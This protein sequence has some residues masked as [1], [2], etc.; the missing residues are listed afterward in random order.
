MERAESELA[1][2][3]ILFTDVVGSTELR[4]RLGDDRADA[5]RRAHDEMIGRAI[6]ANHGVLLRWTGD[7]VKAAFPTSSTAIAAAIA[8]QRAV[9]SYGRR[10]DAV[11][12]FQIRVGV[13]VGEVTN[14]DGDD[15]GVAVIEAARLEALAAPGEILAT[16]LVERLGYRRT[17]AAFED[18]GSRT[19]KGLEKP[20]SIV[21]VL[22]IA[23]DATVLPMPR[24]L[25]LDRRFPLVG[26]SAAME[27]LVR[28]WNAAC[29]GSAGTLLITGQPGMGKTR[30]IAQAA[31]HAHGDGAIVLAGI[32]DSELAVP[33]QPFAMALRETRLTDE[34]LAIA[35]STRA[36]ALGPLFPGSRVSR[37][38]DQGPAARFELFEAVAALLGRLSDLQPMVLVLEDLQWA[39]PPTLLLL[40]HL[41]QH[42]D[43]AR[44][45]I[46]GTYRDEEVA[47]NPQLRDLLAEIHATS[48]ASKIELPALNERDVAEMIATLV[49]S[50]PD[51]NVGTFARRVRDESAGNAFFVCELLDHLATAGQLERLVSDGRGSDRLPIPDSVRDVVGQRLGRLSTDAEELL[52]TAAVIGLTF[53]L[54]Q[55][56]KVVGS[57]IEH[58]LVQIEQFA[59]VALV[60]EI[61]AGRYSFSHAIVRTTL[62]ERMSATRR[63]FA[64][65]R[66]AEAIEALGT[67]HHD[68]L[69]HHWLLAGE[70]SRAFTHLE[71]AA[72]RDLSALAY[73]SAAERY[74]QVLDFV[75]RTP[76]TDPGL[77]ARAYL[78]LGLTRRALGQADFLPAVEQ[79]GR[80]ARKLRDPDLMADAALASIFPGGFFIVAG[81]TEAGLVE[82]CEDALD[83][84]DDADPRKVR[85]MSTLAAHLTFDHDRD[86]RLALL[87]QAQQLA[88]DIGDP[89][90]LGSA[91]CA[92]FIA[93]WDPTTHVRRTEIAKQVGRMARASGDVDL[94]FLGGFFAAF[95]AAERGDIAVARERLQRLDGSI[96]ASRN[97]YFR[98]LAERLRLSLDILTGAPDLQPAIDDLAARYTQRHADTAG[99]WAVQTGVVALQTGRLG[100]LAE[101]IRTLIDESELAPNW[102]AAYGLAL[103][104]NGDR[105]A[106]TAVLDSFSQPPMDYLWLTTMQSLADLAAGVDRA[107]VCERL[108]A[109]LSPFRGLL[110]ITSTGAACYGLVSRT[111]GQLA[112]VAGQ[113]DLAIELLDEAVAQADAI[114]APFE[115]T[116]ARRHLASALSAA[117]R[118]LDDVETLVATAAATALEHG[119]AGE[120]RELLLVPLA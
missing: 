7:G 28:R 64:H 51:D 33:Y 116:S 35:I 37:P 69:S 19:L 97:F 88:R 48:T 61:G 31:E 39:T 47:A 15:H 82:L 12:P 53:D 117:G 24:A 41:V 118:R 100:T 101:T 81:R 95:C 10:K 30:L 23:A 72:R 94:E 13:S 87:G 111:L 54:D 66:V 83:A 80:L 62:L 107:D 89:E 65:R 38:D 5:L 16:D 86:R 68:E 20:V 90:L 42:L 74:Q 43:E 113:I 78:G 77:E 25:A 76:G 9:R 18:V 91:L 45:L 29:S 98:F 49:P 108:L 75:R 46:L 71:F 55:V 14:E 67:G 103:L 40:R 93:L 102:T 36:G 115:A 57:P 110:G 2:R 105:A 50:A 22:D 1:T 96:E 17:D 109:E 85:I 70:E 92:E 8:M 114:G 79:A 26:R 60:N 59:R 27:Q 119:F 52:S 44:L 120:H 11:A 104:V 21:R 3:A 99:T 6:E 58:V 32:C 63:A 73:E 34:Q 84:L 112:L 106:A 56:A 4:V